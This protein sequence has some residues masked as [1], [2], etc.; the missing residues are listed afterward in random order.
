MLHR[1]LLAGSVLAIPLALAG[2]LPA[3]AQKFSAAP[4]APPAEPP[5]AGL[6]P[7]AP[8][9][10][11]RDDGN[12][13]WTVE[14]DGSFTVQRRLEGYQTVALSP[15]RPSYTARVSLRTDILPNPGRV[16]GGG[17][18]LGRTPE[19]HLIALVLAGNTLQL[20]RR[21][22]E[23]FSIPVANSGDEVRAGQWNELEVEVT[24]RRSIA[25]GLNGRRLMSMTVPEDLGAGAAG[26]FIAGVGTAQ[27][28]GYQLG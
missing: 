25:I 16:A 2:V 18:V 15:E 22:A 20:V 19:D 7:L 4:G 9:L 8:H 21:N 17:L 24:D 6:G 10:A 27:F 14:P 26:L 1:R 23:G 5:A 13:R 12:I 3:R 11:S 28:R